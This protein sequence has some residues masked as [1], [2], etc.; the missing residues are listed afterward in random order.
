MVVS[1][2]L[3][4]VPAPLKNIQQ[5]LKVASTHDQRDC[6]VSY[7]CRL[8]ALQ[9]GLK[10]S[11][12]TGEETSFLVKLMNWLETTKKELHDNE[13]IT[14]DVAAQAHL[15]NWALKLFLYADKSDRASNFGKNV[16]QTFYTAGLL[17]DVLTVFGE[18]T[19]EAAQNRKY[20]KWKATYLHNCI[21]NGETPIPGPIKDEDEEDNINEF[22]DKANSNSHS[23]I[24]DD[25]DNT[26]NLDASSPTNVNIF[27]PIPT[28]SENEGD[29][30]T[31]YNLPDL[32]TIK[33]DGGIT[34]S[35]EQVTKAQKYIKWAGSALNY[36]DVP[37]SVLNLQ[38]AIHLLTTGQD[39]A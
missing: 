20:A 1:P 29:G 11:T 17:Y 2:E 38:K 27:N 7:W 21:K 12:K 23:N 10:L 32:K 9:T 16:I 36:D 24:P 4:P 5:Y 8:Y 39:P 15:E 22:S 19:D 25:D 31:T 6:V 35:T 18:L 37:T 30:K 14:N 33:V 3:P 26:S 34:L 28:G 13:A